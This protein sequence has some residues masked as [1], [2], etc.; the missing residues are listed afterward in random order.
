MTE[1]TNHGT[2]NRD[3]GNYEMN[4]LDDSTLIAAALNAEKKEIEKALNEDLDFFNDI[5]VDA[6]VNAGASNNVSTSTESNTSTI[7][8]DDSQNGAAA[9][10]TLNTS[11]LNYSTDSSTD[12]FTIEE[13]LQALSEDK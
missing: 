8:V 13:I 6:L 10:C 1:P 9:L 11:D 7:I 12:E 5:N 4:F 3:S 2:S